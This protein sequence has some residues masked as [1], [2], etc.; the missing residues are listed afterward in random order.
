M[1]ARET[2]DVPFQGPLEGNSRWRRY[3]G[4]PSALAT[5]TVTVADLWVIM[6]A[7]T[8]D[9]DGGGGRC[10]VNDPEAT[11]IEKL[12]SNDACISYS[13]AA[14]K[15]VSENSTEDDDAVSDTVVQLPE[16]PVAR[17]RRFTP[18]PSWLFTVTVT[19]ADVWVIMSGST[20][21]DD[22]DG[23]ASVVKD[24]VATPVEKSLSNDASIS[25]S[26]PAV[27]LVSENS[28]E[29][30]DAVSDTV[31]QFVSPVA[32]W[33]RFTLVPSWLFTVTVTVADVWVMLS[34]STDDTNGG[35]AWVLKDAVATPVE[36]SLSNDASIS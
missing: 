13:V 7:V 21:T 36:K 2:I 34:N 12:L 23:A 26:V 29:D 35:A 9:T 33:R 1:V 16:D 4:E 32:R 24:A 30:D 6:S 18:V 31:V 25:Y 5:V 15:P 8:D 19:V 28:T 11:P 22:T 3:R 10:V 20:S 17:W 14:D 27:R